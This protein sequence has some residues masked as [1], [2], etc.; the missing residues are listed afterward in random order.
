MRL[1]ADGGVEWQIGKDN[2][3]SIVRTGDDIVV[4]KGDHIRL[5][6]DRRCCLM[7]NTKRAGKQPGPS[8]CQTR[9]EGR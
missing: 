1:V 2:V 8:V 3:T 7:F 9:N 6:F 5:H 4:A